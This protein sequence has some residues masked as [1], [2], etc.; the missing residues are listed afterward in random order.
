M[1]HWTSIM[2]CFRLVLFWARLLGRHTLI[3]GSLVSLCHDLYLFNSRDKSCYPITDDGLVTHN[4]PPQT[5]QEGPNYPSSQWLPAFKHWSQRYEE[6]DWWTDLMTFLETFCYGSHQKI[7]LYNW[8][9]CSKLGHLQDWNMVRL[10]SLSTLPLCVYVYSASP[11]FVIIKEC[12]VK[13]SLW[14]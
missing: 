4:L 6:N 9:F 7:V 3:L 1:D 10:S 2:V 13:W 5:D 12:R 14:Y 8:H 11:T